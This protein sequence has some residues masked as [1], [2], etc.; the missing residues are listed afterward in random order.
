MNWAIQII[1]KTLMTKVSNIS[2]GVTPKAFT[3]F[4]DMGEYLIFS[5]LS[6]SVGSN[7]LFTQTYYKRY[8][9]KSVFPKSKL[10]WGFDPIST[11][12]LT[13]VEV[14]ITLQF[15]GT[16]VSISL[17]SYAWYQQTDSDFGPGELIH[18]SNDWFYT[19]RKSSKL[20][21]SKPI[22]INFADR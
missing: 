21:M 7:S 14:A 1:L 11:K 19:W 9:E 8:L 2:L 12:F 15:S 10:I 5:V 17:L 22:P 18:V 20:I 3:V 16:I 4:L 6:F 13:N